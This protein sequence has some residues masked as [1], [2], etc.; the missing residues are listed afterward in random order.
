LVALLSQP[1]FYLGSQFANLDM[2]VAGSITVTIVLLAHVVL[3]VERK[4]P[5]RRALAG[6]YAV[7]AL[8]VLAKGLIGVVIPALVVGAW[9]LLLR[10]WRTI[11]AL[12]WVPGALLL[13]GIAAPWFVVM[14]LRFP[15]FFDYF[16]VVHHFKRYAD[17]GFNN[18]QPFWFYPAVLFVFALPW[19]PWLR[20]GSAPVPGFD[21]GRRELRLLMIV[22]IVTVTAF[23][24]VPQSK[25]IGYILPAVP[26]LAI[27]AA[28]A[29]E[30]CRHWRAGASRWWWG[31][32]VAMS[33][34][35]V[36]VVAVL[37]LHPVESTRE[38]ALQLR[39]QRLPGEPV[40]MLG[41][42][43]FDVPVYA[44]LS[45]PDRLV[46]NWAAPEIQ[47]RDN[48]RKEVA[49]AATFAPGRAGALLVTREDFPRAV[50]GSSVNW[51]I[52]ALPEVERFSFL[53]R[54]HAVSTVR[55]TTL[56]R[57]ETKTPK[58]A[59]ALGCRGAANDVP[60]H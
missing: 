53:A 7:A 58:M 35:S 52:G 50:C 39:D 33:A 13:L 11:G 60:V 2:L 14:E 23:F 47:K 8:G 12:L 37:S 48:W 34:L 27:L 43:Y 30:S 42:Y 59:S 55:G 28:E 26:P 16:F 24:S 21:P 15:A 31:G 4:L 25:L 54:A 56:W 6:A 40:Y 45:D 41:N 51:V 38:I 44:R 1:L 57:V 5:Y 10:R 3:S 22:W 46:E 20:T 18:V 49:D 19:L 36:L 9:L 17:G 29:F 32:A